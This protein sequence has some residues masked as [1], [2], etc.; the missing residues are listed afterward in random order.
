MTFVKTTFST[1]PRVASLLLPVTVDGDTAVADVHAVKSMLL[2]I[3]MLLLA[4]MMLQV[5]LLLLALL[6]LQEPDFSGMRECK[7]SPSIDR[8]I[9]PAW[10]ECKKTFLY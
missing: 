6:S 7:R 4:P 5:F 1:S 10:G 8:K 9:F 2:S 3:Y